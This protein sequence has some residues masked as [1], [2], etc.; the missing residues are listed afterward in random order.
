MS[1]TKAENRDSLTV[2][3]KVSN[4]ENKSDKI[5][6]K[7]NNVYKVIPA[8]LFSPEESLTLLGLVDAVESKMRS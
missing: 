8:L 3:V 4:S 5:I 2:E 7:A 1:K 6:V